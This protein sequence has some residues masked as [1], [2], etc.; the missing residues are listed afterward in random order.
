MALKKDY[1]KPSKDQKKFL[2]RLIKS[3]DKDLSLDNGT[4]I[5]SMKFPQEYKG[6]NLAKA[7]TDILYECQDQT[8]MV[9]QKFQ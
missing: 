8:R 9:K 7:L 2:H 1:R 3:R 6:K 5:Y 4:N